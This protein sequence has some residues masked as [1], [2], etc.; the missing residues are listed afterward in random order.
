MIR[1]ELSILNISFYVITDQLLYKEKGVNNIVNIL[2]D[3]FL[4]HFT[5]FLRIWS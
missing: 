3:I 4:Y 1:Y 5:Q 2:F